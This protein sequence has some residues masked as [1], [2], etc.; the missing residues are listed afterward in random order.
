MVIILFDLCFARTGKSLK[1]IVRARRPWGY[2]AIRPS[3]LRHF[4]P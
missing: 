3:G 1:F 2:K 4:G